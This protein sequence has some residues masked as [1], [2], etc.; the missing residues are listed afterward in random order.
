MRLP[1]FYYKA[2]SGDG[3]FQCFSE[4]IDE[5]DDDRLRV[6]LFHIPPVSQV[7]FSLDLVDCLRKEFPDIVVGLKDPSGHT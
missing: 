3:L 6:Y 7:G 5:V 1:P 4:V 2:P